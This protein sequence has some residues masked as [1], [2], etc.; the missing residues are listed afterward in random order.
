MEVK[1]VDVRKVPRRVN[2]ENV[3]RELKKGKSPDEEI[4][5]APKVEVIEA[6]EIVPTAS[7]PPKLRVASYSRVSSLIENQKSSIENQETHFE[8]LITSHQDWIFAGAYIDE[9]FTA[10]KADT[11]PELQRLLQDCRDK[12]IDLIL[13]KS[14]S[15]FARNTKDCLEMV[16]ELN[17]LGVHIWFERENI[18]TDSMESEFMLTLLATFA[19]D[20]SKS[21]SGNQKWGIRKR[22]ENGSYRQAREPYGFHLT[23]DGWKIKP[24]EADVVREIFSMAANGKGGNYIAKTL[25]ERGIPGPS[26]NRWE[27]NTIRKIIANPVYM[28]DTHYQKTYKDENF[29]QVKNDGT[30]D[31]Y[32]DEGHHEAIISRESYRIAQKMIQ[33][34]AVSVGYGST[35]S[36]Q[37]YCFT[38]ILRC[39][40]CGNVMH[41]QTW[42]GERTCWICHKHWN[43]PELCKMKPVA[44]Q[45]IKAAFINCLNK[46]AWSVHQPGGGILDVYESFLGKNE[47]EKNAERLQEIE[48][49]LEENRHETRKL[50]ALIMRERFLP[51]HR[52]KKAMLTAQE[53]ALIS[54][55]NE[56]LIKGLPTGTLQ[57]LKNYVTKGW[58][59][60]DDP[61]RFPESIFSD[62]IEAVEIDSGKFA[63]F[64]FKCGLLLIES[65]KRTEI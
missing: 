6:T 59:I 39:K 22:F 16:R 17:S 2:I 30:L 40:N 62:F 29:C 36:N 63:Y 7:E 64:K 12:K 32:Y 57:Q 60:T 24:Q 54:E 42:N 48:A 14:I 11:R 34:R 23:D 20:E 58:I 49:A 5:S 13:T 43:T 35:R 27:S 21:I 8:D 47:E 4:V 53:K 28:G 55:R 65:I 61:L 25:N 46:L 45:D 50:T 3:R 38:G 9:G 19:E 15:R 44:D 51:E 26:G 37:R 33:Q 1:K 31:Q 10:T 41:R 52:E 18:H 56:I